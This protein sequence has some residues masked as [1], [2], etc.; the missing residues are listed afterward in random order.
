MHV[1]IIIVSFNNREFLEGCFSS[2]KEKT[3]S[4]NY[5][6]ILVDNASKD[7]TVEYVQTNFPFVNVIANGQNIGFGRANNQGALI[8]NGKY[9]FFLNTDTILINNAIEILY[10]F[11]EEPT[12][13]NVAAC[14]ANLYKK[15]GSPNYSYSI[16]FPSLWS[17]FCYR[18]HLPFPA[19]RESFNSTGE[20]KE[21]AVIIG[22][23]FL[24]RRQH[25]FEMGGFDPAFFMYVE[26]TELNL[27]L[28]LMN[29]RVVSVPKAMITH[30]QGASSDTAFKLK[31]EV[32][33]YIH[34]YKKHY[35]G[36][37]LISYL[38]LE[39]FFIGLKA[40]MLLVLFRWKNSMEYFSIIRSMVGNIRPGKIISST[41]I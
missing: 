19:N 27:R 22:A 25:F 31:M 28:K 36:K 38:V 41:Q 8:A 7:G 17:H 16:Q 9:L 18:S 35:G 37:Y 26:D 39:M 14:G 32:R 10:E 5:E 21:V 29:Y 6:I 24:I 2:I 3:S 20:P 11:L 15:D 34:Y 30:F 13:L 40:L 1:S 12:N 4:I 23:D 33:S